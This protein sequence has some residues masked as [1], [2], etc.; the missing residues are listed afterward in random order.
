MGVRGLGKTVDGGVGHGRIWD[1]GA[2]TVWDHRY[3]RVGSDTV[4]Q[5]GKYRQLSGDVQD[6]GTSYK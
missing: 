6:Y 1:R 4:W 5:D 2:V 3:R